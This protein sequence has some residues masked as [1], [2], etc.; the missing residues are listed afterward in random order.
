MASLQ[1]QLV[2]VDDMATGRK[3]DFDVG[4]SNGGVVSICP[5]FRVE[6]LGAYEVAP[7][8]FCVGVEEEDV[9]EGDTITK[10]CSKKSACI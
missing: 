10:S 7:D 9:D 3:P 4:D 2:T 6:D 5:G 8:G 1:L